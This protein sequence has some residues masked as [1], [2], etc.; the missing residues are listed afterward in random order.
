MVSVQFSHQTELTPSN[1]HCTAH[2]FWQANKGHK[3]ALLTEREVV[4]MTA[5]YC[6]AKFLFLHFVS[7]SQIP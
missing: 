3:Y 2:G 6:M 4:N 1:A 5:C 7:L